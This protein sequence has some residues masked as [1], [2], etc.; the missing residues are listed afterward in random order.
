[1]EESAE[2]EYTGFWRFCRPR[3][4]FMHW[5]FAIL[6]IFCLVLLVVFLV[7]E[8]QDR[9]KQDQSLF[10]YKVAFEKKLALDKVLADKAFRKSLI[11]RFEW[12]QPR[13]TPQVTELIIDAVLQECSAK[14]LDPALVL[15]IIFVESSGDPMKESDKNAVGLMGV[16]YPVW[17]AEP[18]LTD[19][20]VDKKSKLFWIEHNIKCGT[21]ILRR[22]IDEANGYI[23]VA[24][25]RYNSGE[26]LSTPFRM[27]LPY[28]NKIF[29]YYYVFSGDRRR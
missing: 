10:K 8:R 5:L 17:K 7:Q 4:T 22:Y 3:K 20:G 19:N 12:V 23:V 24:L 2:E 28:P 27:D 25:H 6:L 9:C 29:Y 13:S 11:E 21:N 1:M 26:K 16:R 18:E 14:K 15:A